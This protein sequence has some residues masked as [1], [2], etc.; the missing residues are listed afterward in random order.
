MWS[1]V[2]SSTSTRRARVAYTIA[3]TTSSCGW[4]V[5]YSFSTRYVAVELNGGTLSMYLFTGASWL[6]TVFSLLAKHTTR[7]VGEKRA[8]LLGLLTALPLL[9]SVQIREPFT[10]AL[11][12]A[13]TSIPWAIAW[14]VVLKTVFSRAD[15]GFGREYSSFTL[16]SGVGFLAGSL[17]AGL[18]YATGGVELV[19]AVAAVLVTTPYITYYTYYTPSSG[20]EEESSSRGLLGVLGVLRYTLTAVCVFVLGRELLFTQGPV[21]ISREVEALLPGH[22]GWVYYLLYG[23]VY[24]GGALISPLARFLAGRLV[25]KYG[26]RSLLVSSIISYTVLYWSFTKT[27]GIIPLVLWQIPLFPFYD[28]AVNTHVARLL[29]SHLHIQGF[30]AITAFTALGGSLVTLLLFLGVEDVNI[31]G[32]L[33]TT[34][35]LISTALVLY[36]KRALRGR[37]LGS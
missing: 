13:T 37:V 17:L 7:L 21:K 11:V 24:S 30:A 36:E 12:L 1:A 2:T 14:P 18:L 32:L 3:L 28:V 25:D 19:Y 4:G 27:S 15:H 29:P 20:V 26:S 9:L 16:F 31:V 35:S 10:V 6:F 8:L 22:S 34:T 33:V 23:L 5:F